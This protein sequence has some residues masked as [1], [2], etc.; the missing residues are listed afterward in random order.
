MTYNK[1]KLSN[2][3]SLGLSRKTKLHQDHHQ[4][5]HDFGNRTQITSTNSKTNTWLASHRDQDRQVDLK[6]S[7]HKVRAKVLFLLEELA[8][9]TVTKMKM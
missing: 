6:I 4:V 1:K 2:N 9:K 8:S 7:L 3:A 5:I